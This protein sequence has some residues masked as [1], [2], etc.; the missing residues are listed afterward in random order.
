[1]GDILSTLIYI[2][3]LLLIIAIFLGVALSFVY[4]IFGVIPFAIVNGLTAL[5]GKRQRNSDRRA[6]AASRAHVRTGHSPAS[7]AQV[8]TDPP[9]AS[10]GAIPRWALPYMGWG[11]SIAALTL[12]SI[13]AN[14]QTNLKYGG[15]LGDWVGVTLVEAALTA[16]GI[17]LASIAF[18]KQ[19]SRVHASQA[20]GMKAAILPKRAYIYWLIWFIGI[21]VLNVIADTA[22][23]A[24]LG[25]DIQGVGPGWIIFIDGW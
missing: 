5:I 12:L 23:I 21:F 8:R 4:T 20:E 18:A 11:V 3:L 22:Y 10:G 19:R 14:F 15:S 1:M 16:A 2:A 6:T 25:V 7:R 13:V 24:G 17:A 9:P